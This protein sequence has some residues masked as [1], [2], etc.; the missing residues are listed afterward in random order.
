MSTQAP[1]QSAAHVDAG[2]APV[3]RAHEA[4]ERGVGAHAEHEQIGDLAARQRDPGQG[5]GVLEFR[6]ALG[7]GQEPRLDLIRAVRRHQFRHLSSRY[8]SAPSYQS[9]CPGAQ[10][11]L[12]KV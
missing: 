3:G 11:K 12:S 10:P 2:A 1:R 8:F 4:L 5:L 7:L 6:R 9:R